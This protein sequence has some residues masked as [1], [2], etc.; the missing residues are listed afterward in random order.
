MNKGPFFPRPLFL[1][2]T[3][4]FTV[5]TT[6]F[7]RRTPKGAEVDDA[8]SASSRPTATD[9][10]IK[11]PIVL[12]EPRLF[13]PFARERVPVD[14]YYNGQR[15]KD[16]I[17]DLT[18]TNGFYNGFT[19]EEPQPHLPTD[20]GLIGPNFKYLR[21]NSPDA[22]K[23]EDSKQKAEAHAAESKARAENRDNSVNDSPDLHE[24]DANT[25]KGARWHLYCHE[26]GEINLT[27]FIKVDENEAKH[28]WP[29]AL[30]TGAVSLDKM[31]RETKLLHLVASDGESP[32]PERLSF[33]VKEAGRVSILLD[34]TK[35]PADASAS[36]AYIRAE[37]L[38]LRRPDCSGRAGGRLRST[39]GSPRPRHAPIR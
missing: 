33:T 27:F 17:I 36:I 39:S 21:K 20:G 2:L 12:D 9:R 32:Q 37:V 23:V 1:D 19:G 34:A 18:G 22:G 31:P 10:N 35:V 25:F 26:P 7:A 6:G 28:T 15:S 11:G 14:V 3:L 5:T 24:A 30:G 38:P 16:G 4:A 13:G 8:P 29:V